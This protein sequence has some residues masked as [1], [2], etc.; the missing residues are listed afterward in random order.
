MS[1]SHVGMKA[2]AP[3]LL[4]LPPSCPP[5]ATPQLPHLCPRSS[6]SST[7]HYGFRFPHH[8]WC[9]VIFLSCLYTWLFTYKDFCYVLFRY[10]WQKFDVYP[11]FSYSPFLLALPRDSYPHCWLSIHRPQYPLAKT[12]DHSLQESRY[13]RLVED[14]PD[15]L[16]LQGLNFYWCCG[17]FTQ[18]R[19]LYNPLLFPFC[20]MI[21]LFCL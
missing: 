16:R 3:G 19:I 21:L 6:S 18:A 4:R 15:S 5:H 8:F 1:C 9:L 14:F 13:F 10:L 12:S 2:Q 20:Y 7:F 17:I 11:T